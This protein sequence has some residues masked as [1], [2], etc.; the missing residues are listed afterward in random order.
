MEENEKINIAGKMKSLEI[1]ESFVLDRINYLPSC[2]RTTASI[3][4]QDIGLEFTVSLRETEIC[5]E[6]VK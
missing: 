4:K 6:R 2:V 1:G 5:V 3:I